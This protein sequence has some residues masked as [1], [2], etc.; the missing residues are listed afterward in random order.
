LGA[1]GQQMKFGFGFYVEE[2]DVRFEGCIDLPLLFA[3]AGEDDFFEGGFVGFGYA[4]ELAAGDDIEAS[5]LERE[6]AEDGERRV[7]F[8]GVA[9]GVGADGEGMLEELEAL[10]DVLRGV[11]VERSAVLGGEGG[12]VGSVAVESSVAVGKRAGIRLEAGCG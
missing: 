2:K 4:G 9:D 1:G 8:D 5:A 12:E 11:D 7:C 3:Y 6:K 10:E